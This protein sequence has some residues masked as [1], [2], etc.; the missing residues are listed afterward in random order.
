MAI[1]VFHH[2]PPKGWV[3][4]ALEM[5]RVLRPDG[6]S[7]VIEHNPYN[8]VTR[9]IVNTCELD[10]DAILISPSNIRKLFCAAGGKD[11]LIRSTLSV[12]PKTAL[13]RRI[14]RALGRMPFGAQYYLL[15]KKRAP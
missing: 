5:M 6:L 13:L 9:R 10:R 1:C 14:D 15:A 12:P 4:L 8:P 3:E 7:L 2:V 11:V